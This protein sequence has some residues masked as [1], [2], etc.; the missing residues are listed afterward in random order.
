MLGGAEESPAWSRGEANL[1]LWPYGFDEARYVKDLC[2]PAYISFDE[3]LK[4]D[5]P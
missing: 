2:L 4:H 5:L 1:G 3:G